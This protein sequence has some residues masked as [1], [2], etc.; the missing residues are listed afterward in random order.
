MAPKE[1]T[2]LPR[3]WSPREEEKADGN[4]LRTAVSCFRPCT[5]ESG[6]ATG[7][8]RCRLGWF[9]RGW[10]PVVRATSIPALPCPALPMLCRSQGWRKPSR[11]RSSRIEG[12]L[13]PGPITPLLFFFFHF[14]K[15]Q[16]DTVVSSHFS[17]TIEVPRRHTP[18]SQVML[19]CWDSGFLWAGV[20]KE[21][22]VW[23]WGEGLD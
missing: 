19:T 7:G 18:A 4:K 21:K 16:S 10:G 5:S 23:I 9:L 17:Q 22:R 6:V 1:D 12:Q 15:T 3:D 2:H 8:Q 13:L 11:L 20:W 14:P